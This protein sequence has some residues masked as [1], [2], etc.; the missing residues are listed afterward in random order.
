MN[1]DVSDFEGVSVR[2]VS[3]AESHSLIERNCDEFV[4]GMIVQCGEYHLPDEA[5]LEHD[6]DIHPL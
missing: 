3:E 5:L 2:G 4:L 1:A 6:D